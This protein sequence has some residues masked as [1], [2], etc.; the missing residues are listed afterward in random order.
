MLITSL[1]STCEQ[2]DQEDYKENKKESVA[3]NLYAFWH[4]L[5]CKGQFLLVTKSAVK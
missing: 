3:Y 1:K 5:I 4:S 2:I